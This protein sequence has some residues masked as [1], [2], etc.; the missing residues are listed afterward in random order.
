VFAHHPLVRRPDGSKLSKADGA[1]AIGDLL[2][3][4]QTR[5]DVFGEAAYSVGLLPT[6]R[7]LSFEE[8]VELVA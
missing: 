2:D 3:A 5:E 6:S 8:A 4:G 7:P 1:T